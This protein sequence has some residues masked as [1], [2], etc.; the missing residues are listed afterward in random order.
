[1]P[2]HVSGFLHGQDKLEPF[3]SVGKSGDHISYDSTTVAPAFV[4][5]GGWPGSVQLQRLATRLHITHHDSCSSDSV[6]SAAR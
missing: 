5:T 4:S 1:V 2:A 3:G 6:A